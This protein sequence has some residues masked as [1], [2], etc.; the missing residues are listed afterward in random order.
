MPFNAINK[1]SV[2]SLNHAQFPFAAI[3]S[4]L[5]LQLENECFS[6]NC[7]PEVVRS[8]GNP[9]AKTQLKQAMHVSA[10]NW[11]GIGIIFGLRARN[12]LRGTRYQLQK[13]TTFICA[14]AYKAP[15][16]IKLVDQVRNART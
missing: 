10:A 14:L 3:Y 11:H 12:A 1:A 13:D 9:S 5:R 15:L 2:Q 6:E 4:V 7:Y 8:V 16:R